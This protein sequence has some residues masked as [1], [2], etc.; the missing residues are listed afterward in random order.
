MD[1]SNTNTPSVI[2]VP[3]EPLPPHPF[4]AE[5]RLSPQEKDALIVSL[6]NQVR[7]LEEK[8][9]SFEFLHQQYKQLQNDYTLLN[10]EKLRL[11]YENRQREEAF[12]KRIRDLS[13]ENTL[14]KSNIDEK[15]T[16]NKNLFE[17]REKLEKSFTEKNGELTN[18][19]HRANELEPKINEIFC[20]NQGLVNSINEITCYKNNQKVQ[21]EQL[22]C[23]NQKLGDICQNLESLLKQCKN[24]NNEL[25]KHLKEKNK[26]VNELIIKLN[27]AKDKL[28]KLL[29][30]Y[31]TEENKNKNYKTKIVNCKRILSDYQEENRNLDNT[32]LNEKVLREKSENDNTNLNKIKTQRE[33]ILKNLEEEFKKLTDIN[34]K[35]YEKRDMEK[36][37][38]EQLRNHIMILTDQNQLLSNEIDKVLEKDANMM[39]ILQRRERLITLLEMKKMEN[40]DFEKFE[41]SV[42][43]SPV[44]S[45][46]CPRSYGSGR[47][48]TATPPP[49]MVMNKGFC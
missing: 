1:Q 33:N 40:L 24:E 19:I 30:E 28:N 5:Y 17:E 2:P 27:E 25:E 31:N 20:E 49:H 46:R 21:I 7:E 15:K 9:S 8:Q 34:E 37:V 13:N 36:K 38:N 4:C 23:D 12:N 14:L 6:S 29:N 48:F 26:N 18:L 22:V 39:C 43:F 10:E 32:L 41:K 45:H 11:D 44:V 16:T 42:C 35:T 3:I 47:R